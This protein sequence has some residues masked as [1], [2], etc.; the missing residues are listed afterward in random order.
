VHETEA[1]DNLP[2]VLAK[3][4]Y[5]LGQPPVTGVGKTWG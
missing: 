3:A 2:Q 4:T 5:I 1:L